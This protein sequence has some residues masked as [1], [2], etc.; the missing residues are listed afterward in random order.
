MR[1]AAVRLAFMEPAKM[2]QDFGLGA[3]LEPLRPWQDEATVATEL[4]NWASGRRGSEGLGPGHYREVA[5]NLR[6]I[7]RSSPV[8]TTEEI[9]GIAFHML[10]N[11]MAGREATDYGT[12]FEFILNKDVPSPRTRRRY[13]KAHGYMGGLRW[14]TEQLQYDLDLAAL[15]RGGRSEAAARRWLERNPGKH[16]KDAPPPRKRRAA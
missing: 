2:R 4:A 15:V 16:A 9:D 10:R 11:V 1:F 14:M 7:G 3:V 8:Q 13:T 5:A 6:Y 12:S